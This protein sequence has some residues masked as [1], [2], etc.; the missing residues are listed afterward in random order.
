M[1]VAA[2]LDFF[3][4]YLDHPWKV[5]GGLYHCAKYGCN[6]CS[7]FKNMKVWIFRSFGW[8]TP[9]CTPKIGVLGEC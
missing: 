8:K 5:S 9:I 1:V 3:G 7:S 2:I 4:A 6:Q